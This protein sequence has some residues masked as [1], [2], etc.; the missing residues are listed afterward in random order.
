MLALF[1]YGPVSALAVIAVVDVLAEN[2]VF[3]SLTG[4]SLKLSPCILFLSLIY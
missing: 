1:K 3:P 2:V 4:K